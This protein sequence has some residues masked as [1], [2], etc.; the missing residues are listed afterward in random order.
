VG[1]EFIAE[2]DDEGEDEEEDCGGVFYGGGVVLLEAD[3][4]VAGHAA[5]GEDEDD[6]QWQDEGDIVD[7]KIQHGVGATLLDLVNN[8]RVDLAGTGQFEEGNDDAGDEGGDD[9][10]AG[11]GALADRAA[12]AILEKVRELQGHLA[13]ASSAGANAIAKAKNCHQKSKESKDPGHDDAG[14]LEAF[15]L[16]EA[17]NRGVENETDREVSNEDG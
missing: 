13:D 9:V 6:D 4:G 8:G 5:V 17:F 15:K 10:V 2:E 14:E 1:D 7:E 3:E 16:D 11:A 12:D